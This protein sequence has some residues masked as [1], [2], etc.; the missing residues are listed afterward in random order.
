MV[1]HDPERRRML[2]WACVAS[3]AG[4]SGCRAKTPPEPAPPVAEMPPETGPAVPPEPGPQA[5]RVDKFT[6]EYRDQPKGERKCAN[7]ALFIA[8]SNTCKVVEGSISPLGWCKFWAPR[9]PSAY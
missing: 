5:A 3:L 7:C 9:G 4:L 8:E 1:Q 2:Q 6:A